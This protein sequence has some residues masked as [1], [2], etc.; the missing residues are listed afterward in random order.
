M[1]RK[2]F[3]LTTAILLVLLLCFALVACG[4]NGKSG[5]K[6]IRFTDDMTKEQIFETLEQAE[7]FTV[8]AY[9]EVKNE[10]QYDILHAF[11]YYVG[12]HYY[13]FEN[14]IQCTRNWQIFD[15]GCKYA[16]GQYYTKGTQ[17]EGPSVIDYSNYDAVK[18]INYVERF[19]K[20]DPKQYD[21][22]VDIV[23][24]NLKLTIIE[25]EIEINEYGVRTEE[26][27]NGYFIFKDFNKTEMPPLPEGYENYKEIAV[28]TEV[29]YYSP[30]S[31][32]ELS[33]Y[34]FSGVDSQIISYEVSDTYDGKPVKVLD[35]L[36]NASSLKTLTIPTSIVKVER[37]YHNAEDGELH[38]IYKGTKAQWAQVENHEMCNSIKGIRVTCIDGDYVESI[39][40]D[41]ITT[42]TPIVFSQDMSKEQI[43]EVLNG[44]DVLTVEYICDKAGEEYVVRSGEG[45]EYI[46]YGNLAEGIFRKIWSTLNSS[47][48]VSY[49]STGYGY[50]GSQSSGVYKVPITDLI[51][52]VNTGQCVVNNGNLKFGNTTVK[53]Y[54]TAIDMPSVPL[55]YE[56]YFDN[57][58]SGESGNSG[59]T[60]NGGGTGNGGSTNTT[61]G[62]DSNTNSSSQINKI[63]EG[64]EPIEFS[65]SMTREEIIEKLRT[66]TVAAI[67]VL[68][69]DTDIGA[70]YTQDYYCVYANTGMVENIG[71]VEGARMYNISSDGIVVVDYTE[72]DTV[73]LNTEFV[74]VINDV[75]EWVIYALDNDCV[76]VFD[77]N[78]YLDWQG[79]T[80]K[81]YDTAPTMPTIPEEYE[82]Y[83]DVSPTNAVIEFELSDDGTYYTLE[84]INYLV[85]SY[86]VPETYN[87][88]PVTRFEEYCN[89]EFLTALTLPTSITY[90]C[91]Y[92]RHDV[93]DGELHI[94][95]KGT[96]A[97]WEAI[98]NS[99]KWSKQDGVRITCSDGDYVVSTEK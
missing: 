60:G 52:K 15:D 17:T 64:V 54:N 22:S 43:V 24:G 50:G 78:L 61:G 6:S 46:R 55:E 74:Y 9:A 14:L 85:K 89:S 97:Q 70:V 12:K 1:K 45:Y 28:P 56:G 62:N 95:Y 8:E 13:Y 11:S 80:V 49:R 36:T 86:E 77:G 31:Y 48:Y 3:V 59:A 39:P 75:I 65:V 92:C 44:S 88:K 25:K 47:V 26:S 58:N 42:A 30:D 35:I 57:N 72:Y 94:I 53:I 51:E 87:G 96:K 67:V 83:K 68:F 18:E 4:D 32:W 33:Y 29:G 23:D 76:Y 84:E 66:T 7:S 93:E 27:N 10:E 16:I 38:I 98:E 20:V 40:S 90:L 82:G 81:I 63:F 41:I 2:L 19:V 99:D 73:D 79:T 21:F 37:C 69:S 5:H 91:S 34:E 71:F